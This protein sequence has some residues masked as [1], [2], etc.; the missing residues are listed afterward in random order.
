MLLDGMQGISDSTSLTTLKA[1]APPKSK[2]RKTAE[3][4]NLVDLQL[5]CRCTGSPEKTKAKVPDMVRQL[6]EIN[7]ESASKIVSK[8]CANVLRIFIGA[9]GPPG[10]GRLASYTCE[11]I[12]FGLG[13]LGDSFI[14]SIIR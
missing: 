13:S 5:G 10:A 8:L 7:A 4:R 9:M 11:Q 14:S 6:E 1:C 2:D 3:F 12:L